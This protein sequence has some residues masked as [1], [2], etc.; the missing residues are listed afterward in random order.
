MPY[1]KN[2]TV[3]DERTRG[4]IEMLVRRHGASEFMSGWSSTGRAIVGFRCAGRL[5]RFEV[6]RPANDDPRFS[7]N[8]RYVGGRKQ[9]ATERTERRHSDEMRRRWRAL[10]LVIKAK[11]EA[12]ETGITTFESEFMAHIVMPDG[13]TV[14][15]HVA[16]RSGRC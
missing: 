8:S 12:V 15:Q 7:C 10:L 5:V 2:T 13:L 9:S 11:L 16:G 4:E 14:G 3:S 6:P 1:A